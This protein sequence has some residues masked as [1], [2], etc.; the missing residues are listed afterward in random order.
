M[1]VC[2]RAR[3][4]TDWLPACRQPVKV[5]I[6]GCG[7]QGEA[8]QSHLTADQNHHLPS[9]PSSR[10]MLWDSIRRGDLIWP[11]PR[12]R[13]LPLSDCSGWASGHFAADKSAAP[14]GLGRDQAIYAWNVSRRLNVIKLILV[15]SV[16][17]A[18]YRSSKALWPA[19]VPSFLGQMSFRLLAT[20]PSYLKW[21]YKHRFCLLRS[22]E[23]F[24]HDLW[25][26]LFHGKLLSEDTET[27]FFF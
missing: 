21:D 11:P 26:C 19:T 16:A 15:S 13:F 27:E 9:Q 5:I 17:A 20:R 18:I 24:I 6:G 12:C 23:V 10:S 2:L 8:Q 7:H 22:Y 14:T 1:P 3:R 25:K 4:P